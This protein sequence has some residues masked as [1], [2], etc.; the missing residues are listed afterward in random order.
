MYL[1]PSEHLAIDTLS[2]IFSDICLARG[3]FLLMEFLLRG[4]PLGHPKHLQT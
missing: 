3:S 1:P 4:L 2:G